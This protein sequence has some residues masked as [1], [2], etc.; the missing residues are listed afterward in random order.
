MPSTAMMHAQIVA[1]ETNL[2]EGG[3]GQIVFWLIGAG[4]ILGLWFVIARSRKR[5]YN[6]YWDRRRKEQ[7]LRDDDPDMA[8]SESLPPP[9]LAVEED[10][11][12][13]DL[14]TTDDHDA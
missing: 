1:Q 2:P 7:Q 8:K 14:E 10:E 9:D 5:S 11:D 3:G 13:Q 4:V 6:A 12:G